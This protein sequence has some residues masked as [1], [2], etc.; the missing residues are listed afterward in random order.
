MT[1]ITCIAVFEA[2]HANCKTRQS[3]PAREPP[4]HQLKPISSPRPRPSSEGERLRPSASPSRLQ[5]SGSAR[6]RHFRLGAEPKA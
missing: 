6:G 1:I 4:R 2:S 3:R 5:A